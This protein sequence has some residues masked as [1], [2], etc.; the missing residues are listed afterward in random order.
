MMAEQKENVILEINSEMNNKIKDKILVEVCCGSVDDAI[1]AQHGGAHRIELN[2]DLFHG[3]LT[4]S[5]GTIIEARKR[6][7][8]PVMVMIR[9]RE[10][11]FCYTE[12]EFETA[13]QDMRMAIEHGADGIVFGFLRENGRIDLERC[14][15]A[16]EIIGD[17]ESVFHRAFDVVPDPM[18]TLDQLISLGITRILTSGQERSALEGSELIRDLVNHGAGRI[19]ILPGA[20]IRLNNVDRII[21]ETGCNQ[22]HVSSFTAHFD[23]SATLKPQIFFGKALYPPEDRYNMIDPS[24]IGRICSKVRE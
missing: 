15:A 12:A 21:R 6:L 22:V 5:I 7:T 18:D 2:C 23:P 24:E 9:P 19:Q 8:I 10:G 20:G 4:P 13:L 16:L 14:M 3:G 11:G 17:R 1:Q